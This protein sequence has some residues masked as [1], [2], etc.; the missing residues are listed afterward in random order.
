MVERVACDKKRKFWTYVGGV[1]YSSR[2]AD[3]HTQ[4]AKPQEHG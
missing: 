2:S 3:V 1:L 4:K